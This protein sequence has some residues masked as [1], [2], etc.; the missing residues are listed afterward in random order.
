MCFARSLTRDIKCFED[1]VQDTAGRSQTGS[2]LQYAHTPRL[3][4]T[5]EG[6]RRAGR[7]GIN[8]L[9]SM[10][11]KGMANLGSSQTSLP[12]FLERL[13]HCSLIVKTKHILWQVQSQIKSFIPYTKCFEYVWVRIC[14]LFSRISTKMGEFLL[15]IAFRYL[16]LCR[17]P[18]RLD[19]MSEQ[20]LDPMSKMFHLLENQNRGHARNVSQ[21]QLE[22]VMII[23]VSGTALNTHTLPA[24]ASLV[25]L[26]RSRYYWGGNRHITCAHCPCATCIVIK[27]QV[28]ESSVRHI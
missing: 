19:L 1:I 14:I 7:Q 15:Q 13:L 10:T 17:K 9:K 26:K 20:S 12:S 4:L 5:K 23:T 21:T 25:S 11:A 27:W 16:S 6:V 3:F 18:W 22:S 24:T 28:K 2:T 8:Y